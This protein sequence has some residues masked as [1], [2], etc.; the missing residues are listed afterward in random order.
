M[1]CKQDKVAATEK[2]YSLYI[3]GDNFKFSRKEIINLN[4]SFQSVNNV[5]HSIILN[6]ELLL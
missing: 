5:T 2:L 3:W 4:Q 6:L 1:G